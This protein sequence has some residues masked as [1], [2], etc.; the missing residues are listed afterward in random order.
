MRTKAWGTRVLPKEEYD[1]YVISGWDATTREATG[2]VDDTARMS[3][4]ARDWAQSEN[5]R[6]DDI[7]RWDEQTFVEESDTYK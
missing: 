2:L 5:H 4:E 6:E 1:G 7:G 3:R